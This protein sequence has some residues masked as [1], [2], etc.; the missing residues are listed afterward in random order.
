MKAVILAAGEGSRL[1][2]LT[3]GIPKALLP[4]RGKPIIDYIIDNI[5]KCKK[6]D[7]IIVATSYMQ[8]NIKNYL[9]NTRNDFDIRIVNV[10]GMETGGD[11]K[12]IIEHLGIKE[13]ILVAYGDVLTDVDISKII[14][15]HNKTKGL[16]TLGLFQVPKEEIS[17]FGIAEFDGEFI[18]SF[19]EKPKEH[20]SNIA[21]TAYYI[22]EPEAF[23][24]MS[25]GRH[26]IEHVLFPRLAKMGEMRGV[27]LKPKLWIDI[28]TYH[29]YMKA[30]KMVEKLLP[31][32]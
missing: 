8:D 10:L 14:N 19:I 6:I 3:Y 30:N 18:K 20:A 31:P 16:V 1:R 26:K 5:S 21:S 24:Y 4:V 11:L 13:P 12:T 17:K 28:G 23:D 15:S 27:L 22:I 7:E 25:F 32:E 29:S 2:P 9:L